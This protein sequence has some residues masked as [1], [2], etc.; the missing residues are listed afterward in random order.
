MEQIIKSGRYLYAL[1]MAIF[2]VM[3][4][5]SAEEMANSAPGGKIAIYVSGLAL[6]LASIS[7]FIGKWDKL[8]CLLLGF[9]LL[10]FIFPHA[11]GLSSNNSEII[12]ILKNIAL[13]GG[14][15]LCAANARDNSFVN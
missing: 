13:S 9:L 10:L 12:N 3:H 8:A 14:A 7:I 6:I 2:G 11:Q 15:F 4:F 1:P 5:I